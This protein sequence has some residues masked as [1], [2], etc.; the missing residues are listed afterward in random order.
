MF[1]PCPHWFPLGTLAS[2]HSP[3][4]CNRLSSD[5]RSVGMVFG[6][7]DAL[8]TCPWCIPASRP[9]HAVTSS[10]HHHP[11]SP[12]LPAGWPWPQTSGLDNAKPCSI[13]I[14]LPFCQHFWLFNCISETSPGDYFNNYY[15]S[16]FFLISSVTLNRLLSIQYEGS[17]L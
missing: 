2:S 10:S 1:S 15:H 7:S 5:S 17:L 14:F 12:H 4:I 6:P 9:P 8:A 16:W 3:K 13:W 11:P